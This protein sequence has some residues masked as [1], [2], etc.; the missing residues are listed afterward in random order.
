PAA[1]LARPYVASL[2]AIRAR[3]EDD[4]GN[5]DGGVKA[6][7]LK[8]YSSDLIANAYV[9]Y[10]SSG[11][12][13]YTPHSELGEG[14]VVG[15]E[16]FTG[17]SRGELKRKGFTRKELVVAEPALSPQSKVARLVRT[18]LPSVSQRQWRG[19]FAKVCG[20]ILKEPGMDTFLQYLLLVRT[21][22]CAGAGDAELEAELEPVLR[23]T[24]DDNIDLAV[25]WMVPGDAE[26]EKAR[27]RAREALLRMGDLSEVWK[28]AEARADERR[29]A[30]FA[31][32]RLV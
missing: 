12:A 31:P 17:P 24:R 14:E 25:R 7:L 19:F 27:Q 32:P 30:V 5:P 29:G 26:A 8:L 28:K 2:K 22:E 18:E 21:L 3:D 9:M 11:E 15:V 13:L 10:Q 1:E 6:R 4:E 23:R 20:Q 16:Y